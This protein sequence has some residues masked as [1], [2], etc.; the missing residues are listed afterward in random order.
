[1][2]NT[3]TTLAMVAAICTTTPAFALVVDDAYVQTNG[4]VIT[5][6]FTGTPAAPA[7]LITTTL[8][9]VILNA[10]LES[11]GDF[12][13]GQG[14]NDITVLNCTAVADNPNVRGKQ[15]GIFLR[16]T[17][18][19]NVAMRYNVI[20]GV[21]I[22]LYVSGYTGN[23]THNQTI[24]VIGNNFLNIDGRPSD[25]NNGY[26][27]SGQY[28]GQAIHMGNAYNVQAMEFAW[29][30]VI[31]QPNQSATGAIFEFSETSGTASSPVRVHDNYLQGAFPASPGKDLYQFGGMEVDGATND[32]LATT[33]AFI[34]FYNNQIVATAN[35]GIAI[36]AGHDINFSN[37]R[38]VSSGY[39]GN[40]VFYPMSGGYGAAYGAYNNNQLNLP[41]TLFFNNNIMGNTLGL[42]RKS[43]NSAP[44]GTGTPTRA[45]WSLPGQGGSAE[46]NVDFQPNSSTSPTTTDEASEL[47]AF[48]AKLR[49]NVAAVK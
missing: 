10:M 13:V 48:Q 36:M 30:Q 28:N 43:G 7:I 18:P 39:T 6:D 25:G 33:S 41:P 8:P 34:N 44:T 15:K 17:N 23:H 46:G 29:N 49:E 31:N 3:H 24:S 27:E 20:Q 1:M 19:V 35:Y 4:G 22:G 38:V 47:I 40:G 26:S 37:N 11:S 42:I 45:D 2:K 9:V 14:K 32:T 5:G 12:I 21:R 16:V